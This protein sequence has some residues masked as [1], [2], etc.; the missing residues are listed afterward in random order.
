MIIVLSEPLTKGRSRQAPQLRDCQHCPQVLEE[1][2]RILIA[3]MTCGTTIPS[4]GLSQAKFLSTLTKMRDNAVAEAMA[5]GQTRSWKSDVT[6]PVKER[7]SCPIKRHKLSFGHV[8]PLLSECPVH[9]TSGRFNRPA[10][11]IKRIAHS[12][13]SAVDAPAG[14]LSRT[15][16]VASGQPH[17]GQS[18]GSDHQR[19]THE[20]LT[21]KD[22]VVTNHFP[23]GSIHRVTS[24]LGRAE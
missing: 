21:L 1:W 4:D 14:P 18:K 24:A 3:A 10:R 22:T 8:E 15:T 5:S 20:N 19:H 16:S 11:W 23:S 7:R 17:Q 13:S 12:L 9:L 6:S 2:Q